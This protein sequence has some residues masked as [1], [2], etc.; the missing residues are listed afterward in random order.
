MYADD[1]KNTMFNNLLCV[2]LISPG[3]YWF[4]QKVEMDS[5]HFVPTCLGVLSLVPWSY[6]H[7]GCHQTRH[8]RMTMSQCV[9]LAT[10][11]VTFCHCDLR[12]VSDSHTNHENAG[13]CHSRSRVHAFDIQCRNWL[14]IQ[15]ALHVSWTRTSS[16][17]RDHVTSPLLWMVSNL[18][19]LAA[20]S[21]VHVS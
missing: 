5:I 9:Q 7:L 3:H 17:I 6:N 18:C 8:C 4:L 20:V 12:L 21:M 15:V 14:P 16:G 11:L 19:I 2:M 1:M 13:L 10:I